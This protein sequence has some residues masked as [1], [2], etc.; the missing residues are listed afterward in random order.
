MIDKNLIDAQNAGLTAAL[1]DDY[2]ALGAKLARRGLDIKFI[3][4]I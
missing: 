1:N 3:Y 2:A 4:V